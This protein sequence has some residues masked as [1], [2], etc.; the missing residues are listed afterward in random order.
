MFVVARGGSGA[1]VHQQPI[2]VASIQDNDFVVTKGLEVGAEIVVS[3]VQ[4]LHEGSPIVPQDGPPP[5]ASASP[6]AA[7]PSSSVH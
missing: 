3:N 1:V 5:T 2:E 7:P 4:K 6:S